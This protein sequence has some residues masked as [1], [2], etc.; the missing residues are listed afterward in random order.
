MKKTQFVM[1]NGCCMEC[2]KAFSKSGKSCLCQVPK[3]QRRATLPPNGCKFCNCKGCNPIDIIRHK[4]QEM[5][6]K[7]KQEGFGKF[8]RKRQR[9]LDSDDDEN[10]LN[11]AGLVSLGAG[12][13]QYDDWNKA[14]KDFTELITNMTLIN[15]LI[16][17]IGAPSR[18]QSYIFG[19]PSELIE[20]DERK[21]R[22]RRRSPS[23]QKQ[24]QYAPLPQYQQQIPQHYTPQPQNPEPVIY[25]I[26]LHSQFQQQQQQYYP[27]QS[28]PQIM[29]SYPPSSNNNQ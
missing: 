15:A 16:F 11:D 1:K 24:T 10:D 19:R 5:K 21:R 25:Q 13:K 14:K 8:S 9:L 17:G 20:D 12:A 6:T 26:P 22:T 23:E 2:M 7:L 27:T 28:A 4:R 3:A 18:H 29:P